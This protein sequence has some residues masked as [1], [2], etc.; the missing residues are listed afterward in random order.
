[1]A[2]AFGPSM[3]GASGV[4]A[5]VLNDV[6]CPDCRAQLK[7]TSQLIG[8]DLFYNIHGPTAWPP[9]DEG[10]IT[11]HVKVGERF[12][13]GALLAEIHA[14]AGVHEIRAK[15]GGSITTILIQENGVVDRS[16]EPLAELE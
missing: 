3:C 12:E 10:T 13:K 1:M 5:V 15:A 6:T 2:S 8:P 7:P 14:M 11:W 16:F 9:G 4:A